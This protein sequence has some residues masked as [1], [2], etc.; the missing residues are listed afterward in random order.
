MPV[1]IRVPPERVAYML[2]NGNDG[3]S[4]MAMNVA[5]I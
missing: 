5:G 4:F 2:E 1:R 3:S